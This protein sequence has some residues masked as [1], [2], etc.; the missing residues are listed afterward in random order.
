MRGDRQVQ[1]DASDDSPQDNGYGRGRF[2]RKGRFRGQ[3][4]RGA[5][6]E[7]RFAADGKNGGILIFSTHYPE[8]LDEYDRYDS[9]FIT[10]N[11]NG[12]TAENL[13]KILKR[14]DIKKSDAYQS[15]FLEGT[16]PTYEAYMRLKKS[17][18][19]ALM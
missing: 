9:I 11:R 8:L 16:T 10:R 1:F 4:Q 13:S 18:A 5:G 3:G 15:G 7:R 17:I 19:L 2:D 12:I 6:F 14:N